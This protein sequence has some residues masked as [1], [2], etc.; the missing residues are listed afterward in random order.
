MSLSKKEIIYILENKLNITE[1][2]IHEN[3]TVDVHQ[4]VYF[5]KYSD[6]KSFIPFKFGIINGYFDI[7]NMNLISL[8]NSPDEIYGDFL[9]EDNMLTTLEDGPKIVHGKY[10][11]NSNKLISLF[12]CPEEAEDSFYCYE[13]QLTTLEYAPKIVKNHFN[14]KN[15]QL[16]SLIGCPEEIT[17]NFDCSV[18]K[19]IT[20]EYSPKIVHGDLFCSENNLATLF[21]CPKK[22]EGSFY[23]YKN[24]LTTLEH[25]PQYIKEHLNIAENNINEKEIHSF[26]C[27]IPGEI[28]SDFGDKAQFLHAVKIAKINKEKE[29]ISNSFN[30]NENKLF[31]NKKRI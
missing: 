20:L 31:N 4:D 22:I 17:G 5:F 8:K 18:N 1:Y 7:S 24:K 11:C 14:C 26:N 6:I 3:L 2:T 25:F 21:G 13:N 9:C 23:C 19:L 12:G 30:L 28:F 27:D 16:I 15:N 10:F 29:D